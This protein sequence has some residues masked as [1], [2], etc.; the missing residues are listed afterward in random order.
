MFYSFFVEFML[1]VG[2]AY[3]EGLNTIFGTRDIIFVHYGV[4][5]MPYALLG[6]IWQEARKYMVI[7]NNN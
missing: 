6:L 5:A 4:S 7:N 3:I 2:L 1:T